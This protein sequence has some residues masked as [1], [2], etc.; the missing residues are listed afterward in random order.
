MENTTIINNKTI[1]EIIIKEVSGF[2]EV[3]LEQ[4]KSKDRHDEIVKPR[5]L[6]FYF[7]SLH[8]TYSLE[9][10]G[11]H[12]NRDHSTVSHSKGV[13]EDLL[14]TDKF[15]RKDYE[16]IRDIIKYQINLLKNSLLISCN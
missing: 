13:V 2:F 12:L 6:T 4:L 9:R 16:G 14:L 1:A 11:Q 3:D 8:T 7:L 15:Y 5:Q 10:I